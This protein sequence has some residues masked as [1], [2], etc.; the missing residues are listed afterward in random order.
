MSG[1][2]IADIDRMAADVFAR[3]YREYL[4]LKPTHYRWS[5]LAP[6]GVEILAEAL[7]RHWSH[8]KIADHLNC[9]VEEAAEC[10]RRY[11][12]SRKVNAESSEADRLRTALAEWVGAQPGLED[13]GEAE[14]RKRASELAFIVANHLFAAARAGD[15]IM[16]LSKDLE[17]SGHAP[18]A[19]KPDVGKS[20]RD[21]QPRSWGPQWKD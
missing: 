10:A 21:A 14:K 9:G 18:K 2:P 5:R 16:K 1:G 15:D 17:G 8:E 7:D 11:A 19:A 4:E 6:Q 12:M 20:E 3:S 13:M